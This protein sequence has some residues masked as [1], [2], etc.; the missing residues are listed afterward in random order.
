MTFFYLFSQCLKY[1]LAFI[2]IRQSEAIFQKMMRNN[3]PCQIDNSHNICSERQNA[4]DGVNTGTGVVPAI[5]YCS[6]LM[7]IFNHIHF[8]FSFNIFRSK[9]FSFSVNISSNQIDQKRKTKSRRY[10]CSSPCSSF[11]K[12]D[13][14]NV[15]EQSF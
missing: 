2:F 4:K 14:L 10:R 12:R 1:S 6:K 9:F 11:I 13:L 7:P 3:S 5:R 15:I 8:L